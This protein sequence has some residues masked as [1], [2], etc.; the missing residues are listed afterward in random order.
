MKPLSLS[1]ETTTYLKLLLTAVF[2]GG[3]FIAGRMLAVHMAP[4][5]AAFLRFAVASFLLL[6]VLRL[7][8]GSLPR[9]E[10]QLVVPVFLLGFTGVFIYNLLF[11][12]GLSRIAAGRAAVIVACNPVV[13]ALGAVVFFG[14]RLDRARVAGIVLSVSGA[15]TAISRGDLLGLFNGGLGTGDLLLAGCVLSWATYSL[16]GKR[17]LTHIP[18]LTATAYAAAAGTLL[19][20]VPALLEGLPRY[21]AD[22]SLIDWIN[23]GYLALFGTV[24]GFVWYYQGIERI[25]PTRAALFINFVPICALFFAAAILAEPLTWTLGLGTGMVVTGV[26]LTN[27]G[28]SLPRR[29]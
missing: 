13:V 23:I 16:I 1:T 19:L 6:V 26:Y 5:S 15:A 21:M 3:T 4:F 25:G 14:Q 27:N 17:V 29:T 2:W 10:R 24:L 28:F 8:H 18:P 7:R 9:L 22:S 11:F 20:L 12:W